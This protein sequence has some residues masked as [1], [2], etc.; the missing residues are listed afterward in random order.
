MH[1]I[2]D[3]SDP[4]EEGKG[5]IKWLNINIFDWLNIVNLIVQYGGVLLFF[6]K[7]WEWLIL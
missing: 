1:L 7:V 2:G 4:N 3:T 6:T 5:D